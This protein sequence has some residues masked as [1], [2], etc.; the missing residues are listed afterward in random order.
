MQE[1]AVAHAEQIE[2][3]FTKIFAVVDPFDCEGIPEYFDSLIEGNP[4]V[5]QLAAALPSSHSKLCSFIY[6][7]DSSSFV[8]WAWCILGKVRI[9]LSG[10]R[11]PQF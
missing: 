4:C 3:F 8:S 5:R 10:S 2:A 7:R 1:H 9:W 11:G 6:V